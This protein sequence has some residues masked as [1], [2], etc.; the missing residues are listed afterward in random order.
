MKKIILILTAI[1]L[2]L[3]IPFSVGKDPKSSY[4]KATKKIVK[5]VEKDDYEKAEELVASINETENGN[6]ATVILNA[7]LCLAKDDYS[8]AISLLNNLQNKKTA[9]YYSL[10]SKA[11]AMAGD[12]YKNNL[13]DLCVS[14]ARENPSNAEYQFTA[15]MTLMSVSEWSRAIYFLEKASVLMPLDG[16]AD[17]FCGVISYANDKKDLSCEYFTKAVNKGVSD[18]IRNNIKL[19]AEKEVS[20]EQK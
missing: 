3:A 17:Y 8:G 13:T 20:N 19:Y 16:T 18:E 6:D 2:I 11:Y 10:M 12:D 1:S 5:S 15:G 4:D 7:K 14:F 9:Q